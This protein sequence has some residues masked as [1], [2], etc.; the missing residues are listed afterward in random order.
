MSNIVD[1]GRLSERFA[2]GAVA[3]RLDALWPG[4]GGLVLAMV[5]IVLCFL[6]CRFLYQRRIFL[7]L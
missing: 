6:L 3:A 4:F 2:G 7:R 1:F 5:S